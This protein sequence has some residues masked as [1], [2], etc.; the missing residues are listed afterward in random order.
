MKG[1]YIVLGVLCVVLA[2]L[3]ILLPVLPT[4]PFLLLAAFFFARSSDRFLH[5]LLHNRLFGPFIRNYREGH[6]M[7]LRHKVFTLSMLWLTIIL[8][9][10]FAIDTWWLRLLLIGIAMGVTIHLTRINTYRPEL[11]KNRRSAR[12]PN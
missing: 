1:S 4:T 3:G 8:T 11:K 5:W 12:E 9:V 6:G 10:I 7:T 2:F